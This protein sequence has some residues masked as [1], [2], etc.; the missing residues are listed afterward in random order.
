MNQLTDLRVDIANA[1]NEAGIRSVEYGDSK[2]AP[3]MAVIVPS[4]DY[5]SQRSGDSF[6]EYNIN[7]MVLLLGPKATPALAASVMDEMIL[8][9]FFA[10]ESD[11]EIERI[12]APDEVTLNGVNYFGSMIE[13]AAQIILR[14]DT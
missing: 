11:F 12:S 7:L 3:N 5:V 9:A 6:G 10:L 2:V 13:I 14:E 1:L 8:K 4:P